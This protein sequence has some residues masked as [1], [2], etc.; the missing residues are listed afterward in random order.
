MSPPLLEV[1][2]LQDG[3]ETQRMSRNLVGECDTGTLPPTYS[4]LS[5][6]E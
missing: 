1:V 5:Q 4:F 6:T 2:F 3:P